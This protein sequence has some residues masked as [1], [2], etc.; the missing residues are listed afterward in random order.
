MKP[1][2]PKGR[3][4]FNYYNLEE[5]IFFPYKNGQNLFRTIFHKEF[6]NPNQYVKPF[7]TSF[8]SS[9]FRSDKTIVLDAVSRSSLNSFSSYFLS[10]LDL[11]L[12]ENVPSKQ[13]IAGDKNRKSDLFTFFSIL[14]SQGKNI[15][16]ITKCINPK[17]PSIFIEPINTELSFFPEIFIEC[18]ESKNSFSVEYKKYEDVIRW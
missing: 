2:R 5:K 17:E 16:I 9:L 14:A 3:G 10:E 4:G 13:S 7:L 15:I 12:K 1:P 6:Q 18:I 11:Y 8:L